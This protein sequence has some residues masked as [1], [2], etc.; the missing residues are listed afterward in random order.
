MSVIFQQENF[1]KRE[2]LG[3]TICNAKGYF[4]N[5][6][7]AMERIYVYTIDA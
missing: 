6:V 5:W 1:Y 2:I 4:E 3:L 7:Y